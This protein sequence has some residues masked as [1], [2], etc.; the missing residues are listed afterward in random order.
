MPILCEENGMHLFFDKHHH[1]WLYSI[2][3]NTYAISDEHPSSVALL[4]LLRIRYNDFQDNL[5]HYLSDECKIGMSD[6][7]F[8]Y[9]DVI[10]TALSIGSEG[11]ISLALNWI[12]DSNFSIGMPYTTALRR[13]GRSGHYS[14]NVRHRAVRA[15]ARLGKPQTDV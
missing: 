2:G 9:R 1:Q 5:R 4:P 3:G 14:Q 13:I 6:A 7:P 12:E 8:P 10:G 11:W 15:S